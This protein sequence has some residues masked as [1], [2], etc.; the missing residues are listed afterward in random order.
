[1]QKLEKP[2]TD[3]KKTHCYIKKC[4]RYFLLH[5]Q[6]QIFWYG[7]MLMK[8]YCKTGSEVYRGVLGILLL[9]KQVVF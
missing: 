6:V 9:T 7:S 8:K 4:I 2:E 3:P 5:Q 1:M